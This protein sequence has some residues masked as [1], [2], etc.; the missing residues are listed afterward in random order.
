MWLPDSHGSAIDVCTHLR[1]LSW[2]D[3]SYDAG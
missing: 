3:T 2:G 1:S